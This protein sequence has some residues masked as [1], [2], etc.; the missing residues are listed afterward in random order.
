MRTTGFPL[1]LSVAVLIAA[2]ILLRLEVPPIPT[3]FYVFAWYPTLAILDRLVVRLGGESL[4]ARPRALVVML[5][6][7]AV[8]WFSFELLNFRLENWYYVFLPANAVERWIG[9]TLSFATV[10][11][12]ILLCTRL[13]ER[14][15]GGGGLWRQLALPAVTLREKDLTL[16]FALGAATLA[17]TLLAPRTLYPLTWGA[18]WLLAEPLLYR[19]DPERSLFG[20]MAQGRW[21]RIA[22]LMAGGLA[23]GALWEAFNAGA[24][25][26]WIYTIPVLE[27]LKLLEMPPL[28]F[29]GF[30]FFALEAWSLY[31]LLAPRT[32][33]R[34]ILP[35]IAFAALVLAGMDRWTISSTTPRLADLPGAT[36]EA[37]RRL[38][39][40]GHGEVFR[41]ART[42]PETWRVGAGLGPEEARLAHE[43]ARLSALRGIGTRHAA[44]LIA[45][46][47]ATVEALAAADPD[48]VWRIAHQGSRRG[49]ARPTPAEV[50]V[51]IRAARKAAGSS[52]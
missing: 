18:V 14:L 37:R 49:G 47:I 11:P 31:H 51:W 40:A 15:G 7:S 26:K 8:M 22:R 35:S 52:G 19:T 44:A 43:A 39:E 12:A 33:L 10:V 13:L 21:G 27:D 48:S 41:L 3:W 38:Q 36:A 23:A 5:W 4:L 42:P 50:R 9:I 16:A 45:G 29:L 24:R 1:P 32:R 30:P 20:D 34:T 2:V 25:G 17:A 46:G 28:G 6:W